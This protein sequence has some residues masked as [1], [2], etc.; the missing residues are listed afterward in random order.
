MLDYT[1]LHYSIWNDYCMMILIRTSIIER[2][3]FNFSD[4]SQMLNKHSKHG[5]I[6][7]ATKIDE[8]FRCMIL[9]AK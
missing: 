7:R 3:F 8:M 4:M 1:T 6:H 9:E 2:Y 5:R